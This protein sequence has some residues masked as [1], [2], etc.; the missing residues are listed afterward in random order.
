MNQQCPECGAP[1]AGETTCQDY[2]HQMLFWENEYPEA[3]VVHH[4]MVLSYHLQHPS[5]YSAEGLKHARTLLDGFVEHGLSTEQVRRE[6]R[7]RVDSGRRQWKVTA[8]PGD[9][10]S[11]ERPVS[12]TM[13]AAD[14]VAAGPEEYCDNVRKWALSIHES[15]AELA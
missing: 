8:R 14:V 1:W 3:G 6:Q 12:W 2:F 9:H 5:L 7:E 13:T 4:L 11:Y 10:G 15:L